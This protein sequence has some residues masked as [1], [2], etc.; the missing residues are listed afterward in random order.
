MRQVLAVRGDMVGQLFVG[1]SRCLRYSL[2]L[3]S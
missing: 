2:S 3:S 1:L